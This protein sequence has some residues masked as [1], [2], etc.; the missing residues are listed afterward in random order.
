MSTVVGNDNVNILYGTADS[1][2]IF[3]LNANDTL[4]GGGG[5]DY[6]YGG[7]G[8]DYLDGGE[9]FD[10]ALYHNAS[11]GVIADLENGGSEGEAAGDTYV[12]IE[13]LSGGD[14]NDVLLGNSEANHIE[15]RGGDDIIYGREGNDY[16]LGND[17]DDVLYGEDGDDGFN[18][19]LG[20]DTFFGGEGSDN[21]YYYYAENSVS[22]NL[23]TGE[24]GGYAQGD[25]Y[26][27]I[28]NIHGS[29]YDDLLIGDSA[30]NDLVGYAGNDVLTGSDFSVVSTFVTGD[31]S[32]WFSAGVSLSAFNADGTTGTV[33]YET[34]GV[35][36]AGGSPV[37]GQVNNE[38]TGQSETLVAEFSEGVTDLVITFS[39]LI[40]TE[41]GG[42]RGMWQ[43]YGADDNLLGEGIFGPEDVSS[44]SGAGEVEVS[45]LGLIYK[46]TF[47][48]LPTINEAAGN[49]T[50]ASD[51]SDF[52]IRSISYSSDGDYLNGSTGN[53]Q[54][55]G[56]AGADRYMFNVGD[57]AD[58]ISNYDSSTIPATDTLIFG[59]GI[60]ADDLWFMMDG[61]DLQISVLGS[62]DQIVIDD[63][64]NGNQYQHLDI[65]AGGEML[66]T[67]GIQS[68]LDAMSSFGAQ[69]LSTDGTTVDTLDP[70]GDVAAVIDATWQSGG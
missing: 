70:S 43:A 67:N 8:A 45:G 64:A 36:V 47:M 12:N 29:L 31:A 69:S 50:D 38:E 32:A 6:L 26:Y 51:S 27:S 24:A 57:G 13:G 44:S 25:V 7:S 22:V 55:T 1:D 30:S 21:A 37:P 58:I 40:P 41:D 5:H 11:T 33:T 48:A 14:F 46:M 16:L 68:L 35:G 17:G 15:G 20:N 65:S 10:Q 66:D 42:E 2:W 52:Y 19:G 62:D 39:N 34:N 53:D 9:G 63:W 56:G 61:N 3:G 60:T 28:E 4:Y 18:G 49:D 54:L 59:D 23:A